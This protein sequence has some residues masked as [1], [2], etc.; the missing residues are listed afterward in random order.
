MRPWPQIFTEIFERLQNKIVFVVR[1]AASHTRRDTK[2]NWLPS[3]WPPNHDT[4]K[5]L[6]SPIFQPIAGPEPGHRYCVA[7]AAHDMTRRRPQ[8]S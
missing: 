6:G 7:T 1:K 5:N 8:E 2:W 3:L 4:Q